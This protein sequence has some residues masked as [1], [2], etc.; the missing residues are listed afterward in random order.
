MYT[1]SIPCVINPLPKSPP[2]GKNFNKP[3][4]NGQKLMTPFLPLQPNPGT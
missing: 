1:S 2:S 3:K 4:A